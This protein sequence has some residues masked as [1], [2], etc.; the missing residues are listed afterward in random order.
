M[1]ELTAMWV[2]GEWGK[3]RCNNCF[4][5]IPFG[6]Y[7]NGEKEPDVCPKCN[8]KMLNANKGERQWK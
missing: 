6:V 3:S 1:A 5:Q 8:A 7:A 4:A 2:R